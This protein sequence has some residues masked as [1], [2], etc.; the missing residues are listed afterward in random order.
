ML[1]ITVFSMD[2][3]YELIERFSCRFDH[4]KIE[5]KGMSI[6]VRMYNK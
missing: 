6:I 3:A 4:Y 1:T 5:T 2:Q